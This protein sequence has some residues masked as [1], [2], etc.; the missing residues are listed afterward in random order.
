VIATIRT[1]DNHPQIVSLQNPKPANQIG[2]LCEVPEVLFAKGL[3]K[4]LV[5]VYQCRPLPDQ[6]ESIAIKT[7]IDAFRPVLAFVNSV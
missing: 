1:R 3:C 6:S 4:N 5:T 2:R 7:Q